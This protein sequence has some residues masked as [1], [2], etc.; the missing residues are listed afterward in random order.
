MVLG[1][2]NP[3]GSNMTQ[4]TQEFLHRFI[5]FGNC[6]QRRKRGETDKAWHFDANSADSVQNHVDGPLTRELIKERLFSFT[7]D[8]QPIF[9]FDRDTGTFK[10]VEGRKAMV[11]SDTKETVGVFK[12]GYKGH[13]FEMALL[14]KL[15]HL[16]GDGVGYSTA[17]FTKANRA[18]AFVQLELPE[19]FDTKEGIKF[20]PNLGAA[21]SFDGSLATIYKRGF[22]VWQCDNT[23]AAGLSEDGQSFKVKH[24]KYS[25]F[26]LDSARQ[27]LDL[28]EVTAE[29]VTKEISKLAEWQVSDKQFADFLAKLSP[30]PELKEGD[31][32]R[33]RTLAISKAEAIRDLYETDDRAAPWRGTALGVLQATNTYNQHEAPQRGGIDRD[34]RRFD[35]FFSGKT[36]ANDKEV[37][38]LLAKICE[39]EYA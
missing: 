4:L 37:L 24:S 36:E 25:G 8:E 17:G 30:V 26:K 19:N 12:S 33:G 3:M 28:I 16:V 39:R 10:T 22:T 34:V 32:T 31:N 20:R 21:T 35:N 14:D 15:D 11:T 13:D 6:E 38:D 23:V 2:R 7:I 1:A 18:V 5:L 29:Q 27:A 9:I